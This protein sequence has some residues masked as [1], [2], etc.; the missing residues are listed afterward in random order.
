MAQLNYTLITIILIIDYCFWYCNRLLLI[1][2]FFYIMKESGLQLYYSMIYKK[3]TGT[4]LII[5]I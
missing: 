4:S 2:S 3:C 5:I 1:G